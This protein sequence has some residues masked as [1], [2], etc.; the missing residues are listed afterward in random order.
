MKKKHWKNGIFIKLMT[1]YVLFALMTIVAFVLCLLFVSYNT[2]GGDLGT[3]SPHGVVNEAGEV[4]GLNT[5]TEL[6]GWVEELD[7]ANRVIEVYGEKKTQAMEYSQDEILQLVSTVSNE[8]N[9]Y[10]GFVKNVD[11][12]RKFLCI[13]ERKVMQVT[14]TVMYDQTGSYGKQEGFFPVLFAVLFILNCIILSMYLS[15]KIKKPLKA[16]AEGMDRVKAGEENVYLDFKAEAEFEQIRDTFHMMLRKLEAQKEEKETL[17]SRKSQMLLELSHD[18][19][20][21]LSTIKSYAKALEAG[22]VPESEKQGYYSTI[23]L[24]SDRVSELAE[25]MF[26][27]LKMESTGYTLNLQKA[28]ICE[29]LR[30]ICAEHYEDVRQ[31]G[32]T[33]TVEIPETE[34]TVQLDETLFVRAISNLLV[35]GVKYNRTGSEIR[36][37]LEKPEE[38][39]RIIIMDD[40]QSIAE[41]L[42]E[43]LFDAFVRGDKARKTDGGSGLGLSITKAIIEKHSAEIE[44]HVVDGWNC[45]IIRF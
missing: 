5:I 39:I 40:G 13:Y 6:G 43:N 29:V 8:D 15:R 2:A 9:P 4:V 36:V 1:S 22:V 24:K 35:N 19:K 26:M 11:G 31:A 25:N 23:D 33:L 3:L 21:P 7:D 17:E 37:Y 44:Y 18:I 14:T 27:M 32:L 30:K 41:E 10:I 42:R 34:Y 20:T 38:E 28:D 45:F 12:G 16:M